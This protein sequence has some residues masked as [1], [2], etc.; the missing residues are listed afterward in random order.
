MSEKCDAC[1]KRIPDQPWGTPTACLTF[2]G[3]I[4][5]P[6]CRDDL[7]KRGVELNPEWVKLGP[8]ADVPFCVRDGEY[9]LRPG[10]FPA[11]WRPTVPILYRR[12]I[13][14]GMVPP[15]NRKE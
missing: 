10:N 11:R 9:T 13:S 5:C 2:Y 8:S 14:D 7:Q 15:D 6:E 4:V 3:C 12:R 1:Q